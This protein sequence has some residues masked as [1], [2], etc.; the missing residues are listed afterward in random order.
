MTIIEEIVVEFQAHGISPAQI[1]RALDLDQGML[2]RGNL[3]EDK[4]VIALLKI[5]RTY[6]WLLEVAEARY[7]ENESKR[8]LLHHA[9]DQ[10]INDKINKE[11]K[12]K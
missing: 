9:V 6:P 2:S 5:V 4:E 7:D 8:I 1:E 12:I 3:I 11:K 10:M